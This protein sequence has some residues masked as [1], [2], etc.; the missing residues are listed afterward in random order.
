MGFDFTLIVPLLPSHCGFS[1]VLGCGVSSLVKSRVFLSM[2]VQQPVVI[3]V[4]SQEGVR[5]RPSTPPSW[6]ILA[7]V[8]LTTAPPGKSLSLVLNYLLRN[9]SHHRPIVLFGEFQFRK[10]FVL[11]LT[12]LLNITRLSRC[13]RVEARKASQSVNLKSHIQCS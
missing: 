1:S 8:F 3:L 7:G 6:L 4:L 13:P 5:A 2:I 10:F 9:V 12:G 11:P